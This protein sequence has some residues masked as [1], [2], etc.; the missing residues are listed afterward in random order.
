MEGREVVSLGGVGHGELSEGFFG[1]KY[2]VLIDLDLDV[3]EFHY[4]F[5]FLSV[6]DTKIQFILHWG[7]NNLLVHIRYAS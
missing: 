4:V 2:L 5:F 3:E 1:L 7:T 6:K